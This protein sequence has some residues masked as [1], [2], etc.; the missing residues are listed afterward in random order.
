MDKKPKNM[1]ERKEEKIT[2]MFTPT[3]PIIINHKGWAY[4]YY[5]DDMKSNQ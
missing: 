3:E 2:I 5:L 1:P 4:K